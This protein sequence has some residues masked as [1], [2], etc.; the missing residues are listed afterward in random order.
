VE[1]Y[2][3]DKGDLCTEKISCF[4]KV[5]E[6]VNILIAWK[7]WGNV[8]FIV[9]FFFGAEACPSANALVRSFLND[10]IF[11]DASLGKHNSSRV[12]L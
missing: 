9:V 11:V 3:I 2:P 5:Q 1:I 6:E 4:F 12:S 10:C 8:I 7:K